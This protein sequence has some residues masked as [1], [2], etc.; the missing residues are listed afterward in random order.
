[1]KT[2]SLAV[3]MMMAVAFVVTACGQKAEEPKKPAEEIGRA[4]V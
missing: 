3:A 2:R 4:H 1:M